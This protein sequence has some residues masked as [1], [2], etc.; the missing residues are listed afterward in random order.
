MPTI[1]FVTEKKEIQVSEGTNLRHAAM[2]SGISLYN[3]INGFGATINE[4]V[5]CHGLGLCA[6]CSVLITKGMEN[7][8]PMA[9]KERLRL[10]LSLAYVG[11]EDTMR[12]AC[13][14]KVNGDM[15]VVTKPD[16]NLYGENFFS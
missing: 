7:A 1:K 16:L 11:H 9:T 8:S 2:N 15:E 3:G 5:N 4:Y 10:K 14:T 12:L 6:T 13:Q